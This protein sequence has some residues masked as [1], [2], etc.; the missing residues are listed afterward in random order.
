[1]QTRKLLQQLKEYG[2]ISRVVKIDRLY[3]LRKEI[4]NRLAEG[5]LDKATQ[6]SLSRFVFNPPDNFPKI[7]SI[8]VIAIGEPQIRLT[9][10]WN[11]SPVQIIAP[12]EVLYEKK[13][14]EQTE[15]A[16]AEILGSENYRAIQVTTLPAKL[17]AVRSGLAAYGRNNISY[18][19]GL[20]SFYRLKT[21][22]S[23][24]PCE[25]DEWQGKRMLAYCKK[26]NACVKSCPSGAILPDRFLINAGR[27]ITRYN[28][29]SRLPFP[30]WLNPSWHNCLMGCLHCQRVCPENRNVKSW[31]EEGVEF[32]SQ[33]TALLM[34]GVPLD[35]LPAATAAKCKQI[36]LARIMFVFPRNL[37]VLFNQ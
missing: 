1:M 37:E 21:F 27:C 29:R 16:L 7:R 15:S 34:E 22:Y 24:I 17:L 14:D 25:Q 19:N 36:D 33:E 6:N 13:Y 10:T 26:C 23:D 12:P 35:R 11:G 18:I 28:E 9:F 3:D 20:G 2:Y 30:E 32:S 31:I 5:L 8:I 4:E